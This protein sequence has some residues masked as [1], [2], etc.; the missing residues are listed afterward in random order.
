[1]IY[2]IATFVGLFATVVALLFLARRAANR[3]RSTG[4]VEVGINVLS[5]LPIAVAIAAFA[6]GFYLVIQVMSS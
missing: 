4:A 2:F 6:L 5:P 1:M 3:Y